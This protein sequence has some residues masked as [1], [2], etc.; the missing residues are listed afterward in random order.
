MFTSSDI[1]CQIDRS[2]QSIE[3]VV[4]TS[5]MHIPAYFKQYFPNFGH[6]TPI[7]LAHIKDW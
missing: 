5:A 6:F 3:V 1:P 7:N 4:S 2:I